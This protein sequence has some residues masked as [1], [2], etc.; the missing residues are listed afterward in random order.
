MKP[1]ARC[2]IPPE[3]A[4][5]KTRRKR[6]ERFAAEYSIDLNATQAARRAGYS[7]ASASERGSLL[8]K[9]P[10]VQA[11]IA[12]R[13]QARFARYAIDRERVLH[14]IA[15]AAFADLARLYTPD[16]LLKNISEIDDDTLAAVAA[17]DVEVTSRRRLLRV[18]R[19]DKLAALKLL[20]QHLGLFTERVEM[21]P[22]N[23]R[24]DDLDALMA[25]GRARAP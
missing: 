19:L 8:L 22:V 18:R 24:H 11:A 2:P 1:A 10:A 15:C 13:T 16:G 5:G 21:V 12:A 4:P 17:L 7:P 6:R 20:G 9:S 3:P 14:H 23:G 25:E